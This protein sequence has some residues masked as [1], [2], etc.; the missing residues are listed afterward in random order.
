MRAQRYPAGRGRGRRFPGR[1]HVPHRMAPGPGGLRVAARRGARRAAFALP[2]PRSGRGPAASGT[3]CSRRPPRPRYR[4]ARGGAPA[5][6]SLATREAAW[7]RG[8]PRAGQGPRAPPAL[9]IGWSRARYRARVGRRS[10]SAWPRSLRRRQRRRPAARPPRIATGS[11]CRPPPR[12]PGRAGSGEA[13]PSPA[14]GGGRWSPRPAPAPRRAPR[15]SGGRRSVAHRASSRPTRFGSRRRAAGRGRRSTG[16]E[17]R[18]G[19]SRGARRRTMLRPRPTPPAR[20]RDPKAPA[21]P[22]SRRGRRDGHRVAPRSGRVRTRTPCRPR[23]PPS[24]RARSGGRGGRSSD[25]R[26]ERRGAPG[27]CRPGAA[28][29]GRAAGRGA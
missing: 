5:P 22:G 25:P 13:V 15:P 11:G 20:L 28:P 10:S 29:A 1:P 27:G 9:P 18:P 21:G 12:C 8:A 7:R 19:Q 16:S 17:A 23:A 6:A 2:S 26:V 4:R 3:A 14:A 24:E